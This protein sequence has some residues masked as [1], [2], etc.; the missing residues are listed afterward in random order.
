M[1]FCC[2][3]LPWSRCI[4]TSGMNRRQPCVERKETGSLTMRLSASGLGLTGSAWTRSLYRNVVPGQSESWIHLELKKK[5]TDPRSSYLIRPRHANLLNFPIV[6]APTPR[7]ACLTPQVRCLASIS[8][9]Y[10]LLMAVS[11]SAR[12]VCPP[13]LDPLCHMWRLQFRRRCHHWFTGY[14]SC[15]SQT[16]HHLPRSHFRFS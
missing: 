13:T 5:L 11:F 8:L 4:G 15:S 16:F 12:V 1:V 14:W 7:C 2:M 9:Y 10:S 3:I 6:P